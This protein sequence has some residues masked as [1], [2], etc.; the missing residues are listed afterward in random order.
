M[1]FLTFSS[2]RGMVRRLHGL[3][4]GL[5]LIYSGTCG[6][7]KKEGQLAACKSP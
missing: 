6:K 7:K 1:V 4:D 3:T 2:V 5:L